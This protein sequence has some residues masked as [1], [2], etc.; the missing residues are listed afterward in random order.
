MIQLCPPIPVEVTSETLPRGVTTQSRRGW[1]Y[2]WSQP[3]IDSHVMWRVV[4]DDSRQV[5]DV[6]QKEI[7]VDRNWSYGRR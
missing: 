2:A 4:F 3:G 5:V 6:P 1:A 7:L